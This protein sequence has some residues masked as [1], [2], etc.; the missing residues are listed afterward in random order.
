MVL[1]TMG[2]GDLQAMFATVQAAPAY[3]GF[4][5]SGDIEVNP[6]RARKE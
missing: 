5:F 2:C 6:T 4:V 1:R 3:L